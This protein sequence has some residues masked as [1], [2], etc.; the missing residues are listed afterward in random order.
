MGRGG[1]QGEGSGSMLC[2][3]PGPKIESGAGDALRLRNKGS[4]FGFG[5][6]CLGFL[7]DDAF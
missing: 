1:S 7:S 2:Q 6:F 3:Q 5:F 4:S